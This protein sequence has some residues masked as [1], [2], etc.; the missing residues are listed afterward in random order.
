MCSSDLFPSHDTQRIVIARHKRIKRISDDE[1]WTKVSKVCKRKLSYVG[2]VSHN[3]VPQ[4]LTPLQVIETS[5]EHA[6]RANCERLNSELRLLEDDVLF[7]RVKSK[8]VKLLE[9]DT[10]R[11]IIQSN[12]KLTEDQYVKFTSK[13]LSTMRKSKDLDK[14]QLSIKEIN[15]LLKEPKISYGKSVGVIK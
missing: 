5:L 9:A 2:T 4:V 6:V 7:E 10:D 8:L 15:S 12:L 14:L 13:S 3:G 1:L 11:T